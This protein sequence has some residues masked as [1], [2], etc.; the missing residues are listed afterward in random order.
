MSKPHYLLSLH[1]FEKSCTSVFRNEKGKIQ[2]REKE[3]SL[4]SESGHPRKNL[5]NC[6]KRNEEYDEGDFWNYPVLFDT[7]DEEKYGGC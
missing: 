3:T 7:E 6:K 5:Y 2:G 1:N 4:P